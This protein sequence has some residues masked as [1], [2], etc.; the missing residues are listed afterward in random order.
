VPDLCGQ[1]FADLENLLT[2]AAS[3]PN[4]NAVHLTSVQVPM[5]GNLLSARTSSTRDIALVAVFAALI[6][7]CAILPGIPVGQ[8]PIT[9]QTLGVML[10]G[11]V[12]GPVRG[13]LAVLL[14]L[15]VGFA[16]LPVFAQGKSGLGTLA[17]PSAGYLLAF[18][19]AAFL[20]GLFVVLVRNR[21][22]A[23]PVVTTALCGLAASFLIIHPLGIAVLRARVES[24]STWQD[25]IV[26]DMTFWPGDVVKNLVMAVIAVAV[27]RAFPDL[28]P[29][30]RRSATDAGTGTGTA[31]G[32]AVDAP[33]AGAGRA[34]ENIE[35]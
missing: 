24:M 23:F 7:V 18:P 1:I 32:T 11:A 4:L 26:Y 31:P 34:Q 15:A 29:V 5:K 3:E 17:A 9:L 20:C 13:L 25:A 8:V 12:L 27:H 2:S 30:R 22:S 19:I 16:G 14:Y 21:T 10:A 35:A 6:A 28:L 33:V